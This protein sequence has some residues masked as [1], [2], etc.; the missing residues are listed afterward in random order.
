MDVESQ[1][2]E[3]FLDCFYRFK[4]RLKTQTQILAVGLVLDW[5]SSSLG[6]PCY[7]LS[8]ISPASVLGCLGLKLRSF[9]G[10]NADPVGL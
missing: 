8:C 2:F 5:C 10:R 3:A 9:F 1:S 6:A 7:A 4:Q